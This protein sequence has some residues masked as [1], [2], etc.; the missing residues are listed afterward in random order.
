MIEV[1][2][3]LAKA[4]LVVAGVPFCHHIRVIETTPNLKTSRVRDE[5]AR[6]IDNISNVSAE[7]SIKQ[8]YNPNAPQTPITPAQPP[9]RKSKLTMSLSIYH[10]VPMFLL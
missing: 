7:L 8:S 1:V 10:D 3:R 4:T 6:A 9:Q 2:T 5:L